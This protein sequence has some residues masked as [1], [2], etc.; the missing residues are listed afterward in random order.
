MLNQ[1]GITIT[2]AGNVKGI[3]ADSQT[4]YSLPCKIANTGLVADGEGKK[5]VKT[6]TPL[7]GDLLARDTAFTVS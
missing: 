7:S 3:L 2:Q 1:G 6:G 5:I 4:F